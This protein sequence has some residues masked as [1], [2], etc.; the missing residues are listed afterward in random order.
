MVPLSLSQHVILLC[1]TLFTI[2]SVFGLVT[3]LYHG[4]S[5]LLRQF[6]VALDVLFQDV[7]AHFWFSE[8]YSV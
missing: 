8:V 1:H 6:W 2:E 5:R 7:S 3:A 4:I